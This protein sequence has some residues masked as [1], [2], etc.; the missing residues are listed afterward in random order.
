MSL[1]HSIGGLRDDQEIQLRLDQFELHQ[2]RAAA[3]FDDVDAGIEARGSGR[4][5]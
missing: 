4:A 1:G 5:S 3:R 2:Q